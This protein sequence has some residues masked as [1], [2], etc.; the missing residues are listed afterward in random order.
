MSNQE[1]ETTCTALSSAFA[2]AG[3][4]LLD[5]Q[6]LVSTAVAD[7]PG[8]SPQKYA[9]AGTLKGILSMAGKMMGEDG[10]EQTTGDMTDEQIKKVAN[11]AV[12]SGTL[13]WTGFEEDE[14]GFYTVPSLSP[15]HY[16]FA[17]AIARA[18][19]ATHLARQ[20]KAEQYNEG[21]RLANAIAAIDRGED[22]EG[23]ET[24]GIY[25]REEVLDMLKYEIITDSGARTL[26]NG[27][28]ME[29][30]LTELALVANR[31]AHLARQAQAEPPSAREMAI[32]QAVR[33]AC[34]ECYS[35][36]DLAADWSEKMGD[37]NLSDIIKSVAPAGAQ[38]ATA[39][40]TANVILHLIGNCVMDWK[41]GPTGDPEEDAFH[42]DDE[43][44][45]TLVRLVNQA[46][47]AGAQNAEAIRNQAAD[48]LSACRGYVQYRLD[49]GTRTRDPIVIEVA[50]GVIELIE[51]SIRALQTGSANTLEGDASAERSGDHA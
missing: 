15:Y 34:V 7:I 17:R 50:E 38:N 31:A 40:Q 32:A 20:P 28:G 9:V 49:E 8:T 37:L 6:P 1:F 13:S 51:Q 16:Q 45:A 10:A 44:R 46:L 41:A 33:R 29:F 3:A 43:E 39:K 42:S 47:A 21:P 12:K 2:E 48:T 23:P 35:P 4:K 19:I 22:D 27:D 25:T 36:D 5:Y 18:A 11:E 14:H 26:L 30:N 24:P